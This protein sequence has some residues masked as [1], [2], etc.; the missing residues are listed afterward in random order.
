MKYSDSVMKRYHAL[1]AKAKHNVAAILA[2]R[3]LKAETLGD[4]AKEADIEKQALAIYRSALECRR[5]VHRV[6]ADMV[7]EELDA[8]PKAPNLFDGVEIPDAFG[9]LDL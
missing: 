4:A 1:E 6:R 9:G 3:E 2:L 5:D 8:S 7:Q